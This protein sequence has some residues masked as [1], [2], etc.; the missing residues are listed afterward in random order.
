MSLSAGTTSHTIR[1]LTPG[2]VYRVTLYAVVDGNEVEVSL[3]EVV[4][5][6]ALDV[7]QSTTCKHSD[8]FLLSIDGLQTCLCA[9][10]CL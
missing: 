5:Y 1:Q 10:N 9:S 3:H 7:V 6:V 2:T 8:H 4:S